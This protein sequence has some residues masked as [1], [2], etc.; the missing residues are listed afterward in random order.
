MRFLL[1]VPGSDHKGTPQEVLASVGLGEIAHGVD[2]RPVNAG[3]NETGGGLLF[4]W[5]S[6]TQSQFDVFPERQKW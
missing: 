3:P 5:L 2:T 6:A 1:F 4:G